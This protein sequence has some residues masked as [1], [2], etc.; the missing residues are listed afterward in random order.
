MG[1]SLITSGTTSRDVITAVVILGVV[2]LAVLGLA[3]FWITRAVNRIN[4]RLDH[5]ET[6]LNEIHW[7]TP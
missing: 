1:T 5:I 4:R 2:L 3:T 7:P 6:S